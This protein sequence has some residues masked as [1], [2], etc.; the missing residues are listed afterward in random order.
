MANLCCQGAV[1]VTRSRRVQ[2]PYPAGFA[3]GIVVLPNILGLKC[4]CRLFGRLGIYGDID[5]A[6]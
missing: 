6:R 3:V 5:V 4:G 2:K 1:A